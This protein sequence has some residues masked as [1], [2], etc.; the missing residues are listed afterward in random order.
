MPIELGERGM[1]T[2]KKEH[3]FTNELMEPMML[4]DLVL[5]GRLLLLA[6]GRLQW[7][8]PSVSGGFRNDK[9]KR[10]LRIR[11]SSVLVSVDLAVRHLTVYE[12]IQRTHRALEQSQKD[13]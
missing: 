12:P 13:V 7:I 8:W 10:G 5:L 1:I 9:G 11:M 6:K 2:G 4:V 3:R